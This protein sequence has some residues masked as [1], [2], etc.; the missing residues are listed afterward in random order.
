[1]RRVFLS[2]VAVLTLAAS[3]SAQERGLLGLGIMAGAPAGGTGKFWIDGVQAIDVGL[4]YNRNFTVNADY[5]W[6]VFHSLS[7]DQGKA[8]GYV[9]LGLRLRNRV[10]DDLEVGARTVAGAA[11]WPKRYP[12][13]IFA[14]LAPVFRFN[15]SNVLDL[16]GALGVRYYFV[17][18]APSPKTP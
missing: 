9:G 5:L 1:M 16:D 11:Y 8:A 13:E 17:T 10:D 15:A 2:L 7:S 14:E 6:D 18:P 12:I 4:G 3:A